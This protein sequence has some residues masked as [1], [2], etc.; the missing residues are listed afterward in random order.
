MRALGIWSLPLRRRHRSPSKDTK[1]LRS[2]TRHWNEPGRGG[3]PRIG[4]RARN[5]D[6][7][8]PTN[9][10]QSGSCV[11]SR[12]TPHPTPLPGPVSAERGGRRRS[13]TF[14]LAHLPSDL[15]EDAAVA[16]GHDKQREDIERHKVKHVVRRLLPAVPETPVAGALSEVGPLGLNGPKDEKLRMRRVE[17]G[18]ARMRSQVNTSHTRGAGGGGVRRRASFARQQMAA[19]LLMV[20]QTPKSFESNSSLGRSGGAP[21]AFFGGR[22]ACRTGSKRP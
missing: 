2:E 16:E 5:R 10:F 8:R 7:T 19:H 21:A 12:P 6:A 18:E 20:R 13:R 3:A 1:G 9:P 11:C 17:K 4:F 15:G 14:A 22:P